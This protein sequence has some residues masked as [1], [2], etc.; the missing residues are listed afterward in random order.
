MIGNYDIRARTAMKITAYLAGPLAK[1]RE[2]T[3]LK[4]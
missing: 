2:Y 1:K 4:G 3:K